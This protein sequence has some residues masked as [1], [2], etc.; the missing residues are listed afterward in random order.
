[1]VV[2]IDVT[3]WEQYRKYTAVTPG[4][5]ARYGGKFIVRG[6]RMETVE[7]PEEERRIVILEFPSWEDAQS[8]YHSPE[9]SEARRIRE[10]A[11]EGQFLL[12]EGAPHQ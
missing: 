10:G 3:D 6:G 9:Y 1:M 8:F 7:G 4:I 11:A 12:I 5:V 2:R